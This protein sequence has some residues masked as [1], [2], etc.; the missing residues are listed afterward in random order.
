MRRALASVVILGTVP[1]LI[2]AGCAV[3]GVD[4]LATGADGGG[5]PDAGADVD[6]GALGCIHAVPPSRPAADDPGGADTELVAAVSLID[7]GLDAGASRSFDLDDRCT[8]PDPES[9]KPQSASTKHCDDDAG[10]DNAGGPLV[11]KFAALSSQ[12]DPNGVNVRVGEGRNTLMF[13]VRHWNGL[14]NDT[15]VE[16]AIFVSSGT[17][18]TNDAG[19]GPPPKH[20]GTD[21]WGIDSAS[22][23]GGIA[24]PYVPTFVDGN[25]YVTG[26]TV[27]ATLDFPLALG[28]GFASAFISLSGA[29]VVGILEQRATG[30]A[31][32]DA[33]VVGRWGS[34]NLL[35]SLQVAQDPLN[36]G[37]YL[38]G[39]NLT[40]QTLRAEICK[41][42]DLATIPQNDNTGATCD[43]MSLE[44]SLQTEPALL[45]PAT[46]KAVDDGGVFAPCG[47]SYTDQCG[48]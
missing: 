7:F 8:C 10:R 17:S 47:A 9:C 45:G 32:K 5:G 26:G 1:L 31:I 44:I 43:A 16:L 15:A 37:Q 13:R 40:Y 2:W 20:D 48:L 23:V 35:T 25:A 38:C 39:N 12:F 46:T 19:D 28:G 27:V 42:A 41:S 21:V 24:P 11:A 34:R 30:F 3:Y 14:P 33:R 6:A 36:K 4:L 29:R 22:L 18:P